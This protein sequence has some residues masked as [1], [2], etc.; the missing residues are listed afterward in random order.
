MLNGKFFIIKLKKRLHFILESSIADTSFEIRVSPS[1][2][3]TGF[4]PVIR[5]FGIEAIAKMDAVRRSRRMKDKLPRNL[6]SATP[7]KIDKSLE[8]ATFSFILQ[9][10]KLVRR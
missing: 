7:A 5:W 1:G 10:L 9:A 2:K 8:V 4:D 3:A 6:Q